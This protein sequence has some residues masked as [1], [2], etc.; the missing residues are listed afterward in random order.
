MCNT[1]QTRTIIL[2][3]DT[4]AYRNQLITLI[5]QK[6][7]ASGR[8]TLTVNSNLMSFSQVRA[9]ELEQKQSY[10][11]PNGSSPITQIVSYSGISKGAENLAWG[12]RTPDE[13]VKDWLSS[14]TQL[15][16]ILNSDFTKIGAGC[17]QDSNGRLY[18]IVQFGG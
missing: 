4:E 8:A 10:T 14:S 9:K 13:A 2:K 5:N 16:N 15:A 12:Q 18:W 3:A 11:R 6:R 7:T 17:Y 1:T